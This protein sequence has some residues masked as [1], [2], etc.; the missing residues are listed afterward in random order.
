VYGKNE[1]H[2]AESASEVYKIFKKYAENEF[3]TY[4]TKNIMQDYIYVN[5]VAKVLYYF[6]NHVPRNGT[7]EVGTGFARPVEAVEA[8][9]V[10]A[11]RK[12]RITNYELRN[13]EQ[14]VFQAD[15]T[16][17]RKYAYKQA[18]LPLEQGVKSMI[19]SH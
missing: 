3:S 11:L 8:A 12:L 13:K 1:A 14:V 9:V 2:K 7:Y 15:L 17:L 6:F 18:F 16:L 19:K 5:D 10:G 4:V